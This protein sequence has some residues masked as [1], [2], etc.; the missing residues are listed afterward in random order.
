VSI[1][2]GILPQDIETGKS[3]YLSDI[4]LRR[5]IA[6]GNDSRRTRGLL[7]STSTFQLNI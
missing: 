1:D 3:N 2:A 6:K 7:F 5:P 4:L